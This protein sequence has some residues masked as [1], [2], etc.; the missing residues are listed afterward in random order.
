MVL[1]SC[2]I[3][4]KKKTAFMTIKRIFDVSFATLGI[5]LVGWLLVILILVARIDTKGSGLFLQERIG[6]YGRIFQI[7]KIR[8]MHA[9]TNKISHFGKIIRKFKF[10]E[11]PQLVNILKGEMSFVGPRPDI[12]GYYDKLAGEA[13][14]ILELKPG[15]TSWAALKYF[16][17]EA[18]LASKDNPLQYNDEVIFPEK[19][20]LN[21]EYFYR[22]SLKED[23][24]I[25]LFTLIHISISK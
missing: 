8:S 19:V 24:K 9:D 23:L 3:S 14:K 1:K 22:Q 21:L 11:L 16:D 10:D 20:R 2:W 6:Q 15:L 13:R 5:L 7:L 18:I 25:L 4:K 12:P 17:E